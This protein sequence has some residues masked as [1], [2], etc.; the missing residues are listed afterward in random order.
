[1]EVLSQLETPPRP[2]Q[3]PERVA[4]CQYVPSLHCAI[5][6]FGL[7]SSQVLGAVDGA[8]EVVVE[9]VVD[10]FVVVDGP[11]AALLGWA[12][13]PCDEHVPLPDDVLIV[14][15]LHVTDVGAAWAAT[16]PGT[17]N[18]AHTAYTSHFTRTLF[19]TV[20]SMEGDGSRGRSTEIVLSDPALAHLNTAKRIIPPNQ[21]RQT[22]PLQSLASGDRR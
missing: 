16:I 1:M 2:E 20:S 22:W 5:A 3:V 6:P 21:S 7:W 8:A 15:S 13:P 12:I 18:P 10:C 19:F 14:P 17:K 9:V 11:D 4:L